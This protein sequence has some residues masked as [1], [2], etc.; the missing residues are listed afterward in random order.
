MNDMVEGRQRLFSVILFSGLFLAV[1]P[2]AAAQ[3]AQ[4]TGRVT[5][6]HGAPI[7]GAKLTL[8]NVERG[9]QRIASSNQH[10]VYTIPFVPPGNY[11]MTAHMTGFKSA[12]RESLTLSVEQVERLDFEL[13]A[14]GIVEELTVQPATPLLERETSSVSQVIENKTIV[15]LP[16]NGRN[17]S[18]LVALMPGAMPDQFAQLSPAGNAPDA[19]NLNGNR[20]LQNTFLIDGM[21]NNNHLTRNSNVSTQALRP[22]LD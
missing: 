20:A 6:S 21:D 16:L 2:T 4:V 15:T 10:G 12:R 1:A 13:E 9:A 3:T 17:Y 14:G 7:Q 22:S 8:A 11:R 19:F 18:Q 5:D